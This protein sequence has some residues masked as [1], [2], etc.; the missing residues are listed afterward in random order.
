[1]GSASRLSLSWDNQEARKSITGAQL[2]QYLHA[3]AAG[4]LP[5]PSS[6]PGAPPVDWSTQ[7]VA[8]PLCQRRPAK[9]A[10]PALGRDICPVC[11]AT[12]RIVEIQCPD[13]CRYLG[14]A[15]QHPAAAVKRQQDLDL[16][17]LMS[18]MGRLT[19]VQLQLFFLLSGVLVRHTPEGF[20]SLSDAD[21]AEAAGTLASTLETASRGVIYEHAPSSAAAAA[22]RRELKAL[23][24]EVGRGGGSRFERDA[25]EVLRGIERGA[26]HDAP[27]IGTDPAGWMTILSRV[28]REAPGVRTPRPA[29]PLIVPPGR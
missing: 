28:M 22:V 18:T 10:C 24:D 17:T 16:A 19:E 15:Q 4:S 8:C 2:W 23:L 27:G 26:R 13:D 9:R 11:C 12:K 7:M 20:S 29:S 5:A 3:L 25:A 14:R 21:V 1:M 6:F